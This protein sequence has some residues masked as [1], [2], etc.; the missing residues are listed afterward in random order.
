MPER[1]PADGSPPPNDSRR[2]DARRDLAEEL[3]ARLAAGDG[4][5]ARLLQTL[6]VVG[7]PGPPSGAAAPPAD[8]VDSLPAAESTAAAAGPRPISIWRP[9]EI[10]GR[11]VFERP[12]P[13]P[14]GDHFAVRRRIAAAKPAGARRVVHLGE[15]AAAG[16]LYAPHL[17]PAGLL[18]RQLDAAAGHGGDG[19]DGWEVID[20]ARTDETLAGLAATAEQAVQLAPDAWVVFAGNNWDLLETP[21]VSPASPAVE[22]R[23]RFALA[24]RQA[25][26]AGPVELARRRLRARVDGAFARIARAAA[27]APVLLVL[28]AV[29]LLDWAGRQP[30]PWLPGD[31][32]GRWHRHRAAAERH[33]D[34]GRWAAA[35]AEAAA[36]LELEEGDRAGGVTPTVHRLRVRAALGRGDREAALAAARAEVDAERYPLLGQLAAPRAGSE[37]RAALLEAAVR[38][39][40]RCLDLEAVLTAPAP[41]AATAGVDP[42]AGPPEDPLGAGSFLDYCHLG[43]RGM[44]R[45]AAAVAAELVT[46]LGTAPTPPPRRPRPAPSLA[47]A[48]E[49]TALLG[50]AVHSAHR[51]AGP[52]KRTTL[53]SWCR[54][55][56][57]ADPAVAERMVD[58]AA[59]RARRVA[60]GCPEVWTAE[61]Q[62]SLAGPAPLQLQHGWRW[63][64]LDADLLLAMHRALTDT[65]HDRAADRLIG[66]V[67]EHC[68]VGRDPVDLAAAEWLWEP[69]ARFLPDALAHPDLDGR[70]TLRAPW[71]VTG[72]CLV[73]GGAEEDGSE[74][75]GEVEI[76]PVVRL[77]PIPGHRSPGARRR[78]GP[79]AIRL[80]GEPVGEL[81]AT[82]RWSRARVR[83]PAHLLAAGLHRLDLAWPELPPVG[84]AARRGLLERL[85]N[86]V[87]ADLHPVFGE[88]FSLRARRVR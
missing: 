82:Q 78:A 68:A 8:D 44:E 58:L 48:A 9:R 79:V 41:P 74:S 77:P 37:A 32:T 23:Q 30:V 39:D 18:Q 61:Q 26:L 64:H 24:L 70:A 29:N 80:D 4:R 11:L 75:R 27:G 20:L 51:S 87:E 88:V 62:R 40:L 73:S 84:D 19:D 66:I 17:T 57:A 2:P 52:G 3:A 59:V 34:A 60:T 85:E 38:H 25:G 86:G 33:L 28:P 69:L 16:Y 15:S 42:A 12:A 63:D 6:G 5:T 1:S 45:A 67:V 50:A 53:T 46:A 10:G 35:E 55:A 31:G 65:G 13:G 56:L 83:L 14:L 71:P 7:E 47:P 21:E 76:E 81:A 43:R 72:F 36:M 54:R 22:A 49:A